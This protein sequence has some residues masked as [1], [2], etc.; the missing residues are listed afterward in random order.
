MVTIPFNKEVLKTQN[1]SVNIEVNAIEK[2]ILEELLK[3]PTI[4]A[5]ELSV[6]IDRSKRTA[7]RYLASLKERGYI[8]QETNGNNNRW[9]VIK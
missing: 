1:I 5:N 6:I 9:I 4:N 3:N 7:E 8:T 2:I